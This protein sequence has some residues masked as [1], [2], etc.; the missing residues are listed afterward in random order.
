MIIERSDTLGLSQLHQLRGRVG[1]SRERAYAYFLYPPDKPL[2][3]TAHERLATLAQHSDLGGGMAIAMKDLEIRGAGNL[4]G[5]EQS[6]HIA[7]VGF[8]LYVRLVGEAV[9]EFRQ[10][11]G[12]ASSSP[13]RSRSS[14]RSTRTCRTT[15]SRAS[16]CGWRCTSGWPRCAP[17]RTS[18]CSTRSSLDRYGTPPEPVARLL[19]VASFRARAR[20]AGISEVTV[21]GKYVR[22]HPVELPDSRVVRLNRLHPKSLYKAPV[23]TMLV[24]RPQPAGFGAQPPRDEELLDWARQVID[25][26]IEPGSGPER[27]G[28]SPAVRRPDREAASGERAPARGRGPALL[29][30]CCGTGCLRAPPRS[31]TG[32]RS[33]RS[34]VSELAAA[35]CAGVEQAAK[36]GQRQASHRRASSSSSSR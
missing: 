27:A 2:T 11:G 4:L 7:D 9:S 13:S 17:T 24:P 31:S 18:G 14:C 10:D 35:Q 32:P 15:T 22:F 1:R 36:S 25:G 3:E 30:G 23:R 26:V 33:P 21:Q 16:G 6:G 29:S 28:A 34:D 20:D 19:A 12:G 5:G 8:D